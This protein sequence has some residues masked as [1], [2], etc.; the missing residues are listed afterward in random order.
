MAVNLSVLA[1]V[2]TAA[3]ALSNLVLVSPQATIG[4][5]PQNGPTANGSTAPQPP[6]F[7][8][9]YEGEQQVTLDSDI[10]DHY[11]EN[12][13]AIQDQWALKPEG[14]TTRGFIGDLNDIAPKALQPIQAIAERLT[15]IG[16]YTPDLTETA[17]LAYNEAFFAYQVAANAANSAVAAW[18]SVGNAITGDNDGGESVINGQGLQKQTNQTPQQL[19][20]Q[21][22][23][24]YWRNRTLFTVQTPWAVFQDMALMKVHPIQDG[25]SESVTDFE[26]TFKLMRFADT[27]LNSLQTGPAI[28]T[29][30]NNF[31][32][33]AGEQASPE[34][35]LGTQ[36]PPEVAT[37][38]L[39]LVGSMA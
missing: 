12:N 6:A 36:S 30:I 2:T 16:A 24:G 32:G 21:Q 25:D 14:Y 20:F 22:L 37:S 18:N 38:P 3:T 7:L 1:P 23:Y 8:F 33:R 31:Q 28:Q 13:S 15:V 26:L 9:N 11:V 27:D 35:N 19:A 5:Q 29:D 4:Y 34:T 10:T 39:D 17:L